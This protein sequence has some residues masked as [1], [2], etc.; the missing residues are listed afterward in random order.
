MSQ[1]VQYG[2][3]RGMELS[4]KPFSTSEKT[5]PLTVKITPTIITFISH[6]DV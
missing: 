6:D 1:A 2:A 4:R 5:P 3:I